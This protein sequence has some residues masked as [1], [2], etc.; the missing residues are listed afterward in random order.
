M[1]AAVLAP[2]Q[3]RPSTAW[4]WTVTGT[5]LIGWSLSLGVALRLHVSGPGWALTAVGLA[6]AVDTAAYFIGK[7]FGRHQLAPGISPGKTWEG[8][9]AGF[10]A[11]GLAGVALASGFNLPI[12]WWEAGLLGLLCSVAAQLGDLAESMIKRAAGAK[13]AGTA[14]PGHGGLL[15]RLDSMMP[16]IAVVYFF[17]T[18]LG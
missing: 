11:G 13:D 18:W 3:R 1:F 6:F 16:T 15:D 7:A 10:L 8:A 12:A 2:L 17:A 4:V 9:V 14:V 5:L